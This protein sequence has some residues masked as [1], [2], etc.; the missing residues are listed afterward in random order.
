MTY[1]TAT[2]CA[3]T[4]ASIYYPPPP[5]V[6]TLPP[7]PPTACNGQSIT[8]SAA[9]GYQTV[10]PPPVPPP[11]TIPSRNY[12]SP[13]AVPTTTVAAPG[14]P[15]ANT[16]PGTYQYFTPYPEYSVVTNP[17]ETSPTCELAPLP[18]LSL[19]QQPPPPLPPVAPP[20]AGQQ[21][22]Y[23]QV[24]Y[25]CNVMSPSLT[26]GF[27]GSGGDCKST[28]TSSI[29][30]AA[31]YTSTAAIGPHLPASHS[32]GAANRQIGKKTKQGA[33]AGANASQKEGNPAAGANTKKGGKNGKK[34]SGGAHENAVLL[35]RTNSDG[36]T[37]VSKPEAAK[38]SA[39]VAESAENGNLNSTSEASNSTGITEF[40]CDV[41]QLY[42]PSAAVLENHLNGNRHARRVKSKEALKQLLD[43]G[44]I[45]FRHQEGVTEMRCEICKMSVNS[46]HQLQAHL[47]G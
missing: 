2:T 30:S 43:S 42:F 36:L 19:M 16:S 6:P 22:Q 32:G 8:E 20:A 40:Y 24:V 47:Q 34:E 5:A 45:H 41:C 46:S 13:V 37:S 21:A 11:S 15:S 17:L 31:S 26:S 39:I 12:Y 7:P 38:T 44:L 4:G 35:Q 23:P 27:S 25:N 10:P 18:Q 1:P 28:E 3:V 33:N 9:A 14:Y 29:L